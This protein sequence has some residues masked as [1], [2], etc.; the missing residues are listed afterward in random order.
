[1]IEQLAADPVK[2]AKAV[3]LRYVNDAMPG[4]RRRKRGK[5]WVYSYDD[6]RICKEDETL[7]RIRKLVLPPAWKD[8]WISPHENGHLQATGIDTMGRKQYRYHS[9]W[10]ELRNETKFFR[11]IHF[12]E[13]LPKLR[14]QLE[15]DIQL[16]EWN[17]RKV[18]AIAVKLLEQTFM[19][20]GSSAYEKLYGSFGLTTLHNNHVKINGSS[21]KFE[22]KGKKG[23]YQNIELS[24]KK[25]AKLLRKC[26][27]IPGQELLQY[28]DESNNRHSLDSGMVNEYIKEITGSDFSSKDFRTWA[29]TLAALSAFREIGGFESVNEA[30]KNIVRAV[31]YVSARLGNTRTVC[32]KYYIHP[33]VISYYEE[34]ELNRILTSA[35]PSPRRN[36]NLS[37][38][39]HL[40]ISLLKKLSKN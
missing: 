39:E 31:D 37:G 16:P 11:M 21:I 2:A 1:M 34:G 7:N 40:M 9:Q 27:H 35:R 6:G 12:A 36:L 15:L 26:K 24:D 4:I 14:K 22:F 17:Q 8:V 19:R 30:K 28:Y 32:K 13:S 10:N 18:T 20:I 25:L 5:N 3:G 38:D 33:G 23:V 29:G